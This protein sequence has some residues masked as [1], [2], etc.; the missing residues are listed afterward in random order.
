MTKRILIVDDE[1][2]VLETFGEI[3]STAGF[4]VFLAENGYDGVECYQ[5]YQQHIDLVMIDMKMPGMNGVQTVAALREF[6]PD[7]KVILCSGYSES[8]VNT[9]LNGEIVLKR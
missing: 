1:P 7:I 6:D 9:N 5:T 4:Q 8:E 3:L 2:V